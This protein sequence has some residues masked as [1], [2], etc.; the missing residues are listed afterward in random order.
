MMKEASHCYTMNK[1]TVIEELAKW[2]LEF[3]GGKYVCT[4]EG[5]Q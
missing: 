4:D 5:Q 2:P 3:I 1:R